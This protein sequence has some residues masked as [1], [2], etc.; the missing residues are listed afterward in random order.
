MRAFNAETDAS[1]R[2]KV[3]ELQRALNTLGY[4][5]R[6]SNNGVDGIYTP[7]GSTA[8]ALNEEKDKLGV[9]DITTNAEESETAVEEASE[10]AQAA[11][12]RL[13]NAEA[14]LEQEQAEL[15]AAEETLDAQLA[16]IT[17]TNERLIA[18]Q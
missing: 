15:D 18:S 9:I 8:N 16:E 3:M 2:E 4:N 10:S 5:L 6:G 14:A 1:N 7:T 13:A 17:A 12:D 11:A